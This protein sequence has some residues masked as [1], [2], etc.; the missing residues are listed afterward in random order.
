MIRLQYHVDDT[1]ERTTSDITA[2]EETEEDITIPNPHHSGQSILIVRRAIKIT[3]KST[4]S[5]KVKPKSKGK[6]GRTRRPHKVK[7][8][9]EVPITVK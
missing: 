7:Y 3:S 1:V 4:G 8:G 2:L 5:D 6:P 9:F